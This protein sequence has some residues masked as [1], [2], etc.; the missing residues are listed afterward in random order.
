MRPAPRLFILITLFIISSLYCT[1]MDK[2]NLWYITVSVFF[3]ICLFDIIVLYTLTNISSGRKLAN[4]I[5]IDIFSNISINIKNKGKIT[6][7][8][9]LFDN[10]PQPATVEGLPFTTT[11]KKNR[12]I[13]IEY[14]YKAHQHG[15]RVFNSSHLM[16]S[17]PLNLF[18]RFIKSGTTQPVKIYH[19]YQPVLKYALMAQEHRLSQMGVL[20]KR[21]RGEG[22]DFLQLKPYSSGD[23]MRKI[24]W[25]ATSRFQ[26]LISRD[27]QEEK[28]Q[29]IVFL[30]DCGRRMMAKDKNISHFDS[31]LNSML[32]LSYVALRQGDSV[33]LMTMT[34]EPK[35]VNPGKGTAQFNQILNNIYNLEPN[36]HGTDYLQSAEKYRS[37]F[38]K[39]TLV[40]ILSNLRDEESDNIQTAIAYLKKR[41]IV[42][43]ASLKESVVDN[44]IKEDVTSFNQA[45]TQCAA[46]SFLHNRTAAHNSLKKNRVITLDTTPEDLP[47]ELVNS[48]LSVKSSQIL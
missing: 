28:D 12:E 1:L 38:K 35:I 4:A 22:M 16:I 27:Y 17:T 36:N 43:F 44:F 3:T 45:V 7:N 47:I 41:D 21:Q 5:S 2:Y 13:F 46:Y 48:Y 31:V 24:D 32:L 20:K 34:K 25:K 42:I 30:V 19:N 10:Y 8:V 6:T 14:K 9:S 26:K 23:S 18:Q 29:Q 15:D 40:V 33:G 11:I 37:I 39:R